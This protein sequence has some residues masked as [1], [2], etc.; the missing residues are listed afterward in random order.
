MRLGAGHLVGTTAAAPPSR[1]DAHGAEMTSGHGDSHA[2]GAVPELPG[3]LQ[4]AQDGYRLVP[5]TASLSTGAAQ[6]FVF[7][8]LGS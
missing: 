5:V 7:R 6:P 1:T 8:V 4:V 3:G 2:E